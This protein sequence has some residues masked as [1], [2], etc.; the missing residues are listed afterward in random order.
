MNIK[1]AITITL[2]SVLLL[3]LFSTQAR[4]QNLGQS[5]GSLV[6]NVSLGGNQTLSYTIFDGGS[7]DIAYTVSPPQYNP[8]GNNINPTVTVTPLSGTLQPGQ[9]TTVL[10][11]VSMPATDQVGVKWD[12]IMQVLASTNAS[13]PGGAVIQGGLGKEV[14]IYS[15]APPPKKGFS[16]SSQAL[17]I[18]AGVIVA[19]VVVCAAAFAL[20]MRKPAA[21][22]RGGGSDEGT[23]KRIA[24]LEQE[25]KSLKGKGK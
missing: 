6:F 4:A 1:T 7:A 2:A 8:V 18:I 5:A 10:V 9:Q 23:Q 11:S 21:R 17:Y 19:V 3:T 25:L 12:G 20:K 14:I 13:N 22:K 15:N 16:I 24:A